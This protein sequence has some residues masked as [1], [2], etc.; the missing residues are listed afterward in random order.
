VS[1]DMVDDLQAAEDRIGLLEEEIRAI[2]ATA[3]VSDKPVPLDLIQRIA[4]A[5]AHAQG[6]FCRP[7]CVEGCS[8]DCGCYCHESDF[9][10]DQCGDGMMDK[11]RN[12]E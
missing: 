2:F 12:N 8:D 3:E 6:G 5:H 9:A 4:Q 10:C 11:P 7:S 1:I